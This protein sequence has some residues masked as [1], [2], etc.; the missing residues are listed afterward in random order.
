[1]KQPSW[2]FI[3]YDVQPPLLLCDRCKETREIHL[4][5]AVGDLIAQTKAFSESHKYCKEK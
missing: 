2:I 3:K 5:A 4:P 1:M